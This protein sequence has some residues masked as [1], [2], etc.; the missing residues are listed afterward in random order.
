M[1]FRLATALP[2]ANK[3]SR[4]DAAGWSISTLPP[5]RSKFSIWDFRSISSRKRA[6]M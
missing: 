4:K 2:S 5:W 3:H 1:F 6:P